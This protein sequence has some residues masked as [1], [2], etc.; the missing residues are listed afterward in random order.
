[1]AGFSERV[2]FISDIPAWGT[3]L[4]PHRGWRLQRKTVPESTLFSGEADQ[5]GPYC[6]PQRAR[7][8]PFTH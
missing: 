3:T 7:Q 5:V 2:V 1:S 8:A 4:R 6:R